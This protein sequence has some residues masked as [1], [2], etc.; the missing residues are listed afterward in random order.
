M[1][2]EVLP[3]GNNSS[4]EIAKYEICR[5][6]DSEARLCSQSVKKQKKKEKKKRTEINLQI[7]KIMQHTD[8][9]RDD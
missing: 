9:E 2:T 4:Q 7:F 1:I 8:K 5:N 6:W 3:R